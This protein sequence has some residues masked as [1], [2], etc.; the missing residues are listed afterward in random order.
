MI[1]PCLE[2]P[3]FK[4]LAGFEC[5]ECNVD[6]KWNVLDSQFECLQ[7]NQVCKLPAY[8]YEYEIMEMLY[9]N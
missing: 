8:D 4:P 1:E 5:P 7:C 2:A 3:C 9:G 6:M